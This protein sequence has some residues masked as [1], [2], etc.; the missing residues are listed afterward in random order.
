MLLSG[1]IKFSDS[2][3]GL[4]MWFVLAV[5]LL[6][7]SRYIV[8]KFM[9]PG[10]LLDEEIKNDKNWGAAFVEGATAIAIALL[11]NVCFLT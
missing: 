1:Y 5:L 11:V 7:T 3:P 2:L 6:F 8:D 9:L 10:R 4:G